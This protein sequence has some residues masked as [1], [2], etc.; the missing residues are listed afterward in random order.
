MTLPK[1]LDYAAP[2]GVGG[3]LPNS[4]AILLLMD[5]KVQ[6]LFLVATMVLW[7]ILEFKNW[8]TFA[9]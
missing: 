1:Q 6:F 9:C 8:K 3:R 2:Q 4:G 7:L 5:L